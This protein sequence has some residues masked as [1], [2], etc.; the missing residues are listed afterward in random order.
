MNKRV[1]EA[2][3]ILQE[4]CA[5]VIVEISK[6]RRFG[7]HNKHFHTGIKHQQMLQQ[8]IGDVFA[9]VDILLEEGLITQSTLDECKQ[10]KKQ[11]LKQ[12]S[13]LYENQSK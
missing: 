8:E 3:D 2:L 13:N 5:E 9:L 7:F 11:K 6:C 10:Q 12:W 1:N 4:E